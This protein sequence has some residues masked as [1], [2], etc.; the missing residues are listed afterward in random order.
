MSVTEGNVE[1]LETTQEEKIKG[2]ER[3]SEESVKVRVL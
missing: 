3:S 2:Q 1:R